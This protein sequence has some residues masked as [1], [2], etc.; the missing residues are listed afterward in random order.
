MHIFTARN[1]IVHC[2]PLNFLLVDTEK[3][4]KQDL[5]P[6]MV[7]TARLKSQGFVCIHLIVIVSPLHRYMLEP[8]KT[9]TAS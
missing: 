5:G 8:L 1:P 7:K 4:L 9:T 3:H 2:L 6:E